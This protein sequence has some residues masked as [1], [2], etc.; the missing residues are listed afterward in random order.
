MNFL[1]FQGWTIRWLEI[2]APPIVRRLGF[3]LA[4]PCLSIMCWSTYP[5][6]TRSKSIVTFVLQTNSGGMAEV[7]TT[8]QIIME[9]VSASRVLAIRPCLVTVDVSPVSCALAIFMLAACALPK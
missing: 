8:Y 9:W 6:T 5:L 3:Q 4:M 1:H 7:T 2:L